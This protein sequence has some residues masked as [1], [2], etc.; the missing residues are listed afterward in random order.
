MAPVRTP[1]GNN[2]LNKKSRELF[3]IH[4]ISVFYD[5]LWITAAS[6]PYIVDNAETV[7]ISPFVRLEKALDSEKSPL[8]NI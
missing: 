5:L 7:E 3:F 2:D 6:L 8:Y 4:K 1:D